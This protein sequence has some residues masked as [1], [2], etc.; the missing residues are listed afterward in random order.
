MRSV[1]GFPFS[2]VDL[3]ACGINDPVLDI[4]GFQESMDPESIAASFVA[5]PH[6][7]IGWQAETL[8]RVLEFGQKARKVPGQYAKAQ[9]APTEKRP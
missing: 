3:D 2:P 4:F 6:G 8:L 7:S 9:T 1:F 5:A